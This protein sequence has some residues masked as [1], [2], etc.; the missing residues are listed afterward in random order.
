MHVIG[1]GLASHIFN[2]LTVA[3]PASGPDGFASTA[4]TVSLNGADL[5]YIASTTTETGS[6]A[7]TSTAVVFAGVD[8]KFDAQDPTDGIRQ[9]GQPHRGRSPH[10]R[11]AQPRFPR[12]PTRRPLERTR[13]RRCPAIFQ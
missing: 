4:A 8:L 3:A 1:R 5:G 12:L 6:G 13:W 11:A 2:D 7:A 10:S 9:R